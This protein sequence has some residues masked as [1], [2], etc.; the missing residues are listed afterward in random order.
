MRDQFDIIWPVTPVN[1]VSFT[2]G[3]AD[4]I[5]FK[6]ISSSFIAY[7]SVK[8][9]VEEMEIVGYKSSKQ[10]LKSSLINIR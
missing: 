8:F 4:I 5:G 6:Q 7:F 9:R 3:E 10:L 2:T 1:D